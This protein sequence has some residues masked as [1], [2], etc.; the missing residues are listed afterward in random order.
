V[1][2]ILLDMATKNSWNDGD[3]AVLS[4]ASVDSYYQ[5]F[6][7]SKAQELRNII[8]SSL[9]FDRLA[10]GPAEWREIAKRAKDAL[11]RI[12]KESA[13][14]AQRVKKHGVYI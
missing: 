14:N 11:R 1:A 5:A 4:R 8:N 7:D 13:I 6:K 10:G 9:Q 2:S 3:I 12:G